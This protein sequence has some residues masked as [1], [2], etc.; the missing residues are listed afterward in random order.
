MKNYITISVYRLSLSISEK[1]SVL[2]NL[3]KVIHSNIF[4]YSLLFFDFRRRGDELTQSFLM[5]LVT[6]KLDYLNEIVSVVHKLV[7]AFIMASLTED[8]RPMIMGIES[9]PMR[10]ELL[11][12]SMRLKKQT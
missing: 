6:T 7:A 3:H 12:K 2:L 5:I 10:K 9:I 8:N 4:V 1:L 11:I